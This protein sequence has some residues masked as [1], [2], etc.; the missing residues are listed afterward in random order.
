MSETHSA[1]FREALQKYYILNYY[2][3][4]YVTHFLSYFKKNNSYKI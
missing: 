3:L 1:H 2:I 4:L